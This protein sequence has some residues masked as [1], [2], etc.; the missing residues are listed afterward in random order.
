MRRC[1]SIT[2]AALAALML[3]ALPLTAGAQS[4]RCTGKDGKR[5]Y[6]QVVPRECIGQPYEKLN[7][8]GLVI[9]RVEPF[10]KEED[11]A[12]KAAAEKKRHEEELARREEA[13]RARALL[14]TYTSTK[15]IE[16][17]RQRALS[18]IKR[19]IDSIEADIARLQKRVD[20]LKKKQGPDSQSAIKSTQSQMETQNSLLEYKKK[21]AEDINAKYDED[22]KRYIEL[23]G[24][25]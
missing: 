19:Q 16:G 15:E 18:P 17:A 5:Y 8:Q 1:T 4:F 21:E 14:A 6:G 23:T 22:K 9:E 24:G 3:A 7:R 2:A 10:Y 25:K 13:R 12:A 11:P 20:E